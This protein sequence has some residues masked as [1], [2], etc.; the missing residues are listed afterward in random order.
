MLSSGIAGIVV[1][2]QDNICNGEIIEDSCKLDVDGIL[3]MNKTTVD[4]MGVNEAVDNIMNSENYL[5]WLLGATG[6]GLIFSMGGSSCVWTAAQVLFI[7]ARSKENVLI[8]I[9]LYMY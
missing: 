6:C 3:H 2:M 7:Y 9:L 5:Y 8:Y 4:M 1:A